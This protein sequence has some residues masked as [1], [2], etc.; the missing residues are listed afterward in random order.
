MRRL[1]A[2]LLVFA[3]LLL[4]GCGKTVKPPQYN[5]NPDGTVDNLR[6][7]MTYAQAARMVKQIAQEHPDAWLGDEPEGTEATVFMPQGT[8]LGYGTGYVHLI[9]R[10][11]TA[12]GKRSPPAAGG[13]PGIVLSRSGVG[14]PVF[15]GR[16]SP[17]PHGAEISVELDFTGNAGGSGLPDGH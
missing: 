10:H 12:E 5:L 13:D 15:P 14:G 2:M 3:L 4:P 1:L 11:F 7:G 17:D 8:I 9:F 16:G 6:W